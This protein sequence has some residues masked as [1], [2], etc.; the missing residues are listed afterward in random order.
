MRIWASAY[1][2]LLRYVRLHSDA[3]SDINLMHIKPASSYLHGPMTVQTS[4]FDTKKKMSQNCFNRLKP[5]R[6]LCRFKTLQKHWPSPST[7]VESYSHSIAFFTNK[8]YQ[9][10]I[11]NSIINFTEQSFFPRHRGH[12][13]T[14]WPLDASYIPCVTWCTRSIL[15]TSLAAHVDQNHK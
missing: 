2:V 9:Y 15:I 3:F 8:F 13:N 14:L 11:L 12:Q 5:L 6:S 1:K 4:S 7:I 10:I